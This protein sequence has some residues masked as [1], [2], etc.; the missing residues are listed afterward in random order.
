[1]PWEDMISAEEPAI[2]AY[3]LNSRSPFNIWW[4]ILLSKDRYILS[5]VPVK[6]GQ[7]LEDITGCSWNWER[8]QWTSFAQSRATLVAFTTT[9]QSPPGGSVFCQL[10]ETC[11]LLSSC[12]IAAQSMSLLFLWPITFLQWIMNYYYNS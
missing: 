7:L 10:I 6:E 8:D 9:S 2:W 5:V 4:R 11:C 3:T 12:M 1:M